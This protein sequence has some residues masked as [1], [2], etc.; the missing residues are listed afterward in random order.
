MGVRFS[1]PA[2]PFIMHPVLFKFGP[3]EIRFYGLMYVCAILL[4]IY[5]LNKEAQRKGIT[6]SKDE[7]VNAVFLSVLFG[8]LGARVYYVIFNWDYYSLN[9]K[10][11][12]AIWRGGLASHGGFIGGF[13]VAYIFLRRHKVPLLK[14]SDSVIPLVVLSEAF[15]RFGNFMNGEA[16]GTPTNLPWGIVFPKGSPA[17]NEFPD[18]AVHPTMLY[19]LFYNLSVFLIVWLG[20]RKKHFQD[21]FVAAISIILYSIGRFFIEGLRADSLYIGP[22][23]TAQVM[24]VVLTIIM[25]YLIISKK[26]WI[27]NK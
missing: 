1:P 25:G 6:L 27:R 15:V 19:Q 5:L 2:L 14:F 22:I 16:H 8:L 10:E 21:G 18:T 17:G 12:P 13:I 4:S 3:F 9:W 20:L 23:R 7:I 24:S 26:L 11:I